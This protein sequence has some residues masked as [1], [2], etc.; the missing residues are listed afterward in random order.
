MIYAENSKGNVKSGKNIGKEVI[1]SL[2]ERQQKQTALSFLRLS[3]ES[4]YLHIT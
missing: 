3:I 2:Q 1:E 4:I